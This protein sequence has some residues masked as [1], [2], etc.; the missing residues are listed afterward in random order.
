MN[1]RI[2]NLE[3]DM[4]DVKV[5]VGKIETRLE[6]IEKHMV[7]KGQMA[8]WAL[9]AMLVVGGS[10]VGAIWWMAQQYLAPIL[11]EIGRI[12]S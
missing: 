3:R 11:S 9:S 6:S 4:T 8:V 1:T 2:I 5:A 10:F 7:T 12:T